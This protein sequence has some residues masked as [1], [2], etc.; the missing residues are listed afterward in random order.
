MNC[1]INNEIKMLKFSTIFQYLKNITEEINL[2]FTKK[3]LYTQGLG[4]NHVCLVEFNIEHSWFSSYMCDK[5]CILGINCE[6]FYSILTCLEKQNTFE[7]TYGENA[8]TLNIIITCDKVIK[9]FEMKLLV[10]ESNSFDIPKIDYTSD[11]I[12]NS[13]SFY[14]YINQLAIFGNNLL[15]TCDGKDNDNVKLET[16]GDNG[17]MELVIDDDYMEEYSVEENVIL[18]LNYA[19]E[20]IKKMTN[21]VKLNKNIALH[22]TEEAPLK[23]KYALCD[24]VD[25]NYLNIYLAP[26]I[27]D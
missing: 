17:K 9:N 21:F 1:S 12:I 18:K 20:Y 24:E 15:I 16:S 11:I 22:L 10:I 26:K 3:G 25:N 5:D 4:I 14:D 23:M 7:M 6:V 2:K 19:M 27:D 13:K 8:D